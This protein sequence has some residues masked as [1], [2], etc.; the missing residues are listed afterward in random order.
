VRHPTAIFEGLRDEDDVGN[1]ALVELCKREGRAFVTL[2]LDFADIRAYPPAE[3]P[4]VIVLRPGSHAKPHVLSLL[5]RVTQP[6]SIEPVVGRLWIVDE[7][8]IRIREGS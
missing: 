8:G 1:P 7:A 3:H 6:L 5:A 4:G 2:D